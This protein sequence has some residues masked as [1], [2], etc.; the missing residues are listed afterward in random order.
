SIL[1]RDKGTPQG[2]VISPLISNVFLHHVFDTWMAEH[3]SEIPFERF[4]DDLI[5]H[6]K[7][8]AQAESI[9]KALTQR[10]ASWQLEVIEDKTR[11]VY[12]KDSNRKGPYEPHLFTFLGYTFKPRVAENRRTRAIFTSFLPAISSGAVCNIHESIR[13]WQLSRRTQTSLDALAEE[14]NE[15]IRGWL[16]YYGKFYPSALD[17]LFNHIDACL[18]RWVLRKY[19]SLKRS[20]R[21]GRAWL[22]GLQ[23]RAPALLAHWTVK[24]AGVTRAV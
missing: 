22:A 16:N 24:T 8:K 17:P 7:T 14:L 6:C 10:L 4:A 15:Q 21:R 1:S 20:P 9:R 3:Y 23:S 18:L 19:K 13:D 2:S 11:I 5:L 12:C